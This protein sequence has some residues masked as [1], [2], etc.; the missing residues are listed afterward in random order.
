MA[1]YATVRGIC[2]ECF[3]QLPSKFC[4]M[5]SI[6]LATAGRNLQISWTDVGLS[7]LGWWLAGVD[8]VSWAALPGRLHVSA[9]LQVGRRMCACSI[10]G[11]GL[12]HSGP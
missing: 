10:G 1:G 8:A 2:V 7:G 3:R 12:L 4:M 9:A 5:Q 11:W 6:L